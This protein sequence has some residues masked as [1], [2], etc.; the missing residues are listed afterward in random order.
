MPKLPLA[1][2]AAALTLPLAACGGGSKSD[3]QQ[4]KDNLHKLLATKDGACAKL[5]TENFLKLTTGDTGAKGAEKCDKGR[6]EQGFKK[7]SI[8]EPAVTGDKATV[9]V[10]AD[11]DKRTAEMVKQGGT[12][13]L[14]DTTQGSSATTTTATTD[15]LPAATTPA[16]TPVSGEETQVQGTVLAWIDSARKGD[17]F[18]YC[19]IESPALLASQTGKSG[20][21]A[22]LAC[23]KTAVKKLKVPAGN[24]I[25]FT[26]TDVTGDRAHVA[27]HFAGAD[28]TIDLVKNAKGRWLVDQYN[29]HRARR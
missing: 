29:G 6:K 11:G 13:K 19:G 25:K 15:T 27:M 16:T 12:W 24:T 4:I 22:V 21:A 2:L 10:T 17:A 7:V 5:A 28:G 8:G 20:N 9:P 1:V 18:A 26:S 3:A 23:T 14:D